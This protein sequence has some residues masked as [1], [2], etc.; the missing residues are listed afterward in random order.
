MGS[1]QDANPASFANIMLT[2][3]Q[4]YNR[5]TF[6]RMAMVA[7][8]IEFRLTSNI[9]REFPRLRSYCQ[10]SETLSARTTSENENEQGI[11]GSICLLSHL[12]ADKNSLKQSNGMN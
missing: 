2:I 4:E 10:L 6:S 11:P 1:S 12:I 7:K 5:F 8:S 3:L 9:R